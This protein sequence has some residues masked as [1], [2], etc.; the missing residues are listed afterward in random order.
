MIEIELS[1]TWGNDDPTFIS[2][3]QE[4]SQQYGVRVRLRRL[5]WATAWADLFTIA[6]QGHGSDVSCVGSSWVSTLAKLDALRSFKQS[7]ITQIGGAGAF[8]MSAWQST[9]LIGDQRIWSIPWTGWMYVICYRKDILQS[10]GLD[11]AKTFA[12][13]K[14]IQDLLAA[15]KTSPIEIPWL[16]PD[17]PY[18]YIDFLHTAA[19]WVWAAGGE[20]TSPAGNK[21]LFASPQA[22]SG[23]TDWLNTYRSV[24]EQYRYLNMR[25]SSDLFMQGRVAAALVDIHAANTML[26]ADF[27]QLKEENIGFSNLT[28]VPWLG[29]GNF[30][31]WEHTRIYPERERAAVELVKF[32]SSKEASLQWMQAADLLPAR[33]D[34]LTEGYPRRNPLHN[35]VMS[36]AR[37]GRSYENVP[38]WRRLETQLCLEL[39]ASVKEA[40]E[41]P[42]ADSA[43]ILRARLEPLARRLNIVLEKYSNT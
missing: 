21:A 33:M 5:E 32:L 13:P 30:V 36:A 39:G 9:K 8:I 10:L 20:F 15:L 22:I 14:A 26:D 7:E 6:S 24:P 25:Q 34:A 16:N 3:A 19:S 17:F 4:F 1:Y 2:L 27:S 43:T 28:N 18:P 29:G 12:T 35:V 31:I 37:E 40:R 11:P 38:H 42:T 41:N 23:W